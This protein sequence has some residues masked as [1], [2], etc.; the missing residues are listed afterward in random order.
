MKK[1]EGTIMKRLSRKLKKNEQ[2]KEQE[3]FDKKAEQLKNK[4]KTA[5]LKKEDA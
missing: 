2:K 3:F 4:F 1:A 5:G